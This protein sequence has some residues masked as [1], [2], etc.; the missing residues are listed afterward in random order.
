MKAQVESTAQLVEIEIRSERE[1]IAR[2]WKGVTE[3]GVEF[4]MLVIRVAVD[5]VPTTRSSRASYRRSTRRR[6]RLLRS[7]SG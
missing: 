4:Q 6:C 2:V 3:N 1:Q 7:I 5:K